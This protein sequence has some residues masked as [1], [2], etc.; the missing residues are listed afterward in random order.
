MQRRIAAVLVAL[1][2]P[3]AIAS[4]AIAREAARGATK[5]AIL[6]ALDGPD[7]TVTSPP[8]C[9]R[10]WTV[11]LRGVGRWAFEVVTRGTGVCSSQQPGDAAYLHLVHGRWRVVQQGDEITCRDGG[12]SSVPVEVQADLLAC[13]R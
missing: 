6:S 7:P 5:A 11:N 12:L 8:Q 9:S 13:P 2:L 4:S 10:A 3:L 1:A